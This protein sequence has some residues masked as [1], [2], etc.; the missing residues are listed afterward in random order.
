MKIQFHFIN[1]K[2][3]FSRELTGTWCIYRWLDRMDR[4]C[5]GISG[6][7][8]DASLAHHNTRLRN[9]RNDL[10]Y[11]HLDIACIHSHYSDTK[12][13]CNRWSLRFGVQRWRPSIGMPA[14]SYSHLRPMGMHSAYNRLVFQVWR[15]HRNQ[16]HMRRI[17]LNKI[18]ANYSTI[19]VGETVFHLPFASRVMCAFTAF[20]RR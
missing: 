6:I 11:T 19:I 18:K 14:K 17:F 3:S 1:F 13:D 20:L 7:S 16:V 2:F 8:I 10:Q 5:T 9:F 12:S 4:H 15:F